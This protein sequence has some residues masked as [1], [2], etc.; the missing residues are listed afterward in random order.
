MI[1]IGITGYG[2]IGRCVL[3]AAF[4][5]YRDKVRV[6]AVNSLMPLEQSALLTNYDSAHGRFAC[7]VEANEEGGELVV[8]GARVKVVGERDPAKIAWGDLGVDVVLECTGKFKSREAAGAHLRGGAKKVLISAPCD[9]EVDATVVFGVNNDGLRPEH[10]I[11]SAAS[12]T[13]NCLAPVVAVLHEAVGV[14]YG[15]LTTVHAYTGDQRL[16][17]RGHP[18]VRRA[19]AAAHSIIPTKTG[20]AKAVAAVLPD[21]KGKL[22]GYAVRVPTLNV[23]M[24]DFNFLAA[25][26]TSVDEIGAVL[27]DAAHARMRGVLEYCEQPLVSVDFNHN[28][29]SSIVDAGLTQ[30]MQGNLVKVVSWYDNEWGFSNR[31]IDLAMWMMEAA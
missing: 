4:E 6:A 13:T 9:G 16:V 3:R 5:S 11:V 2:R 21:L 7:E 15:L 31:M 26:G 14:Q 10:R 28:P 27:R 1:N 17:D 18:D 19:R 22:H 20:A 8:D 12:C 25:R 23:S 29:A 24:V 30:V